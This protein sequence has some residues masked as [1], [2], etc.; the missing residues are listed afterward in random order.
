MA[1]IESVRTIPA[2]PS[3]ATIDFGREPDQRTPPEQHTDHGF[4]E[5]IADAQTALHWFQD[6]VSWARSI[7]VEIPKKQRDAETILRQW[8]AYLEDERKRRG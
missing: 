8:V 3:S 2:H 7:G 1:D 4:A 5:A 6:S